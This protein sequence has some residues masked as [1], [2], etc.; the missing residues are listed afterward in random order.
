MTGEAFRW[1]T[2]QCERAAT[3]ESSGSVATSEDA[4]E[5]M[6]RTEIEPPWASQSSRAVLPRSRGVVRRQA[7]ADGVER[8]R[9][10]SIT[11]R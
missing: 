9:S 2:R 11:A 6:D 4:E 1:S 7:I 3:N 10:G 5:S 8:D